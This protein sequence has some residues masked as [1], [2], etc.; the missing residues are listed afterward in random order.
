[1]N[2]A[3]ARDLLPD[4]VVGALSL[5]DE[6]RV[7]RHLARC[8]KCRGE[9]AALEEAIAAIGLAL[10]PVD[11]PPNLGPRIAARVA[12]ASAGKP[13]SSVR[14]RTLAAA[15]MAAVLVAVGALGWAV[16]ER[17]QVD[18]VRREQVQNVRQLTRALEAVGARPYRADL[19]PAR[20]EKKGFGS[21]A[22][23]SA[24]RVNDFILV[25]VVL[26]DDNAPPY[27]VKAMDPKGRVLSR[28]TLSK[29]NNGDW[30]FYE[31]TQVNLSR[32]ISVSVMDRSGRAVMVGSIR[33][34]MGE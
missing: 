5:M 25:G 14:V 18:L 19:L 28:G 29:T 13:A 27:T 2:C 16:A 8:T 34:A 1:M 3:E 9:Q 15:T 4:R 24:T 11:P 17:G 21:V 23:Y 30:V 20:Q 6:R 33:P 32:A 26:P 31:S 22:I 7:D 12:A 10:P